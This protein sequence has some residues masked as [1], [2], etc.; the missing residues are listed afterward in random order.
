MDVASIP[1]QKM[2]RYAAEDA[3]VTL[4]LA[5]LLRPDLEEKGQ[6]RVFYDIEARVLPVLVAMEDE[7]IALDLDVLAGPPLHVLRLLEEVVA[8]PPG[9]RQDRG[10]LEHE[11]LLPAN[12]T[13]TP[14]DFYRLFGNCISSCYTHSKDAPQNN[15]M[16]H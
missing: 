1:V 9:D 3:D 6:H 14:M 7:G 2:A 10:A 4:Q 8:N 15:I 11:V 5:N 16:S 12:L 13:R